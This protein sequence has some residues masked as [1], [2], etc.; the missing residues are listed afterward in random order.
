MLRVAGRAAG[1]GGDP[2]GTA[3]GFA[4]RP[5]AASAQPAAAQERRGGYPARKAERARSAVSDAESSVAAGPARSPAVPP[6]AAWA[7]ARRWRTPG[8]RADQVH[9]TRAHRVGSYSQTLSTPGAN[10]REQAQASRVEEAESRAMTCAGTARA[11]GL[12]RMQDRR[13]HAGMPT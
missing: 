5:A 11:D 4:A 9:G 1:M 13:T 2:A 12:I 10:T 8:A 6:A 7:P 3:I